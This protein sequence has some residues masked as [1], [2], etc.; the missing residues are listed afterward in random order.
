M[1]ILSDIK[2]KENHHV[3]GEEGNQE[4]SRDSG[5]E[6]QDAACKH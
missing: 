6:E 5:D 1:R 3:S 4:V 2:R